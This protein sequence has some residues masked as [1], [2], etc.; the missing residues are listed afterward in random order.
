M[1]EIDNSSA[2]RIARYLTDNDDFIN[3]LAIVIAEKSGGITVTPLIEK[4]VLPEPKTRTGRTHG[5]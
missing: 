5:D 3:R 1:I 2:K 4:A